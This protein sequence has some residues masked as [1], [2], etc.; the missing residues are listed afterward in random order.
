MPSSGGKEGGN[1][2]PYAVT[3]RAQGRGSDDWIATK[4]GLDFLTG[5]KER[6][7]VSGSLCHLMLGGKGRISG[8]REASF[9]QWGMF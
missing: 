5:R 7:N 2:C 9:Q 6:K 4:K 1:T 8:G 3:S